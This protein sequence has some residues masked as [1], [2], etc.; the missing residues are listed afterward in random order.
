MQNAK[1]LTLRL[2]ALLLG[3]WICADA[4]GAEPKAADG[5]QAIKKAQGMIRQLSQEKSALEAEKTAWLNEKAQLEAKLK[6][7]EDSVRK[8][9]PLQ[10]EVEQYKSTLEVTKSS[11]DAQL[12]AERQQRQALL[13]KHNDVVVKA[14]AINADNQLLV[15]AVKEREQWIAQCTASNTALRNVNQDVLKKYQDKGFFQQLGELDVL[16]G[17]GSIESETAVEDYR[18]KLQQLKITPFKGRESAAPAAESP[19]NPEAGQ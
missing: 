8:L 6:T 14:N 1:T 10:A 7:L 5:G 17:I 4:V 12:E 16:T 15:Q 3:L 11:L 13:Q 9:Q 2:S 19:A 18:Y